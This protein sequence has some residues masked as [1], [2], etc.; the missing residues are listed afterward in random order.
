MGFH[1]GRRGS[2]SARR[3]ERGQI[4]VLMAGGLV[5][6][7]LIVGLVIDTGVAFKERRGAQNISDLAAMA[8]T[9]IIADSY[10]DPSAGITGG[11]V[12]TAIAGSVTVNACVDPCTWEAQYI[13]PNPD[14]SSTPLGAVTPDD[15]IPAGA[16]GVS[17]TTTQS[18]GTFFIRIIGQDHWDV[19]ATAVASTSRLQ[20]PPPGIL[21][22][23][24]IFDADYQTGQI[25]TLT[26]GDHGPGN[27]G[28]LSWLGSPAETVLADSICTPDNPAFDFPF[29]FNGSTGVKNSSAIRDCIDEYIA[30]QTVV[31]VPIWRQTNDAGGHNLEYEIVGVAA[32]VLTHYDQHAV[33]VQGRFV[34]FYAYPGVPAGFGLPPCSATTDP[35]CDERTNFIGLIE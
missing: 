30:N 21:I 17:V 28:W 6:M 12:Y 25:Y 35:N 20:E 8:G 1:T 18:P 10:L 4:L 33:E 29:W 22:P 32:F 7:L 13:Q 11:Q 5:A 26:A 24:G 23:I 16:Q 15:P 31:Y 34:E 9:R 19:A 3:R 14:F 27:F 2:R